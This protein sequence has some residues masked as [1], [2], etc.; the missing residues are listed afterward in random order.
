MENIKDG[1]LFVLICVVFLLVAGN[2]S[3]SNIDKKSNGEERNVAENSD[4]VTI[5]TAQVNA[6]VSEDA[7]DTII[8]NSSEYKN[9]TL[10]IDTIKIRLSKFPDTTWTDFKNWREIVFAD[11]D[12]DGV[13]ELLT[14]YFTG[15]AHCCFVYNF[16]QKISKNTYKSIFEFVGGEYSIKISKNRLRVSF[17]EQLGYFFTCYACRIKDELPN[18]DF[19]P[20]FTM[21][22]ENSNL[23]LS[24]YDS[25]LNAN[26]IENLA[27][28]KKRGVPDLDDMMGFDDGTRKFY[29]EHIITYY[30]NN[31]IRVQDL[32]PTK[33]IFNQYYIGSDRY[34]FDQRRCYQ[35]QH[36]CRY[37]A[38]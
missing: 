31:V 3:C 7:V 5:D 15:G 20:H 33:K 12:G 36:P 24:D 1:K 38:T 13:A 32:A 17:Y 22:Y 28:L 19:Y 27:F 25:S 16:Y 30:F 2:I 29:A 34:P 37:V 6:V 4:T 35:A 8:V 11:I 18:K 23:F 14:T 21:V 9:I 10:I 26:I